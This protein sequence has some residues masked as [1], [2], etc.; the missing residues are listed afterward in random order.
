MHTNLQLMASAA[1]VCRAAGPMHLSYS[2]HRRCRAVGRGRSALAVLPASEINTWRSSENHN[3]GDLANSACVA[4]QLQQLV[5]SAAQDSHEQIS[6]N[7]SQLCIIRPP[8][9]SG[10]MGV[11]P[12]GVGG[13]TQPSDGSCSWSVMQLQATL[14]N[15][16]HTPPSFTSR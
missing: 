16:T 5:F 4:A 9:D 12:V 1:S 15:H 10:Y 6:A 14:G 3:R 13:L 11:G 2:A 7:V 8:Y